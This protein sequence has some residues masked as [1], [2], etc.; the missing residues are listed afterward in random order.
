MI[1]TLGGKEYNSLAELNEEWEDYEENQK[2]KL[3]ALMDL[4]IARKEAIYYIDMDKD[5]FAVIKGCIEI[6][7]NKL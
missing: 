2:D 1:H 3:N 7:R 6:R 4:E 5:T